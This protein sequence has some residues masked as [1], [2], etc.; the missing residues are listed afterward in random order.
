MRT[1]AFAISTILLSSTAIAPAFASILYPATNDNVFLFD[2]M[3]GSFNA[4][5]PIVVNPDPSLG[6]Q[7][8][9]DITA[10]GIASLSS[11]GTT[12]ISGGAVTFTGNYSAT[13][14]FNISAQQLANANGITIDAPT[15]SDVVINVTGGGA[16]ILPNV[17]FNFDPSQAL[18]NLDSFTSVTG[19][20]FS[21]SVLAP[22]A[23]VTFNSGVFNGTLIAQSLTGAGQF[24]FAPFTGNLNVPGGGGSLPNI[25]VP[26]PASLTLL[27]VGAIALLLRR[28]KAL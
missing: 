3:T 12:S 28:R 2:N 7:M 18:W 8:N 21:G 16:I 9:L 24:D 22:Y 6:A 1:H 10:D 13:N 14:I 20:S 11:T 4:Q 23:N 19:S 5:G 26:E 25:I 17:S 15:S 27:G